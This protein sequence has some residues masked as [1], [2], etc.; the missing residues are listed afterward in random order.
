MILRI[1][2]QNMLSHLLFAMA[3]YVINNHGSGAFN[4]ELYYPL[5]LLK[6]KSSV[7]FKIA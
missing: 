2:L 5:K 4:T 3:E 1:T 6:D 7:L